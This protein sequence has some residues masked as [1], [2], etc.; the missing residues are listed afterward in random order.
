MENDPYFLNVGGQLFFQARI[1]QDPAESDRGGL[2]RSD[3][4]P[5]GTV[6]IKGNTYPS[7]LGRTG[8]EIFWLQ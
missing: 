1:Q 5:E 3:G 6:L 7:H 2:F 8:R 4:T